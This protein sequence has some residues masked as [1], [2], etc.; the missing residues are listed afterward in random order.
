MRSRTQKSISNLSVDLIGHALGLIQREA[1]PSYQRNIEGRDPPFSRGEYIPSAI[2]ILLLISG[3]DYHLARLKY[4]TDGVR[5]KPPLPYTPDLEWEIDDFFYTKID[6][7]LIKRTEKRLKEQLIELTMMRDSVAHPK[8]YLI[9]QLMRPDYSFTK[10][11]AKLSGG[12][13]HGKKALQRKLKRSERSKCLGL[14]LVPTWISYVDIVL[15]VLVLNRLLNLLEEK[16]GKFYSLIG[17]LEAR[18]A[19]PGFFHGWGDK[20]RRSISMEEWAQAFFDSLSPRDQRNVEKRLG[21]EASR[22]VRK[23]P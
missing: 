22:Y 10:Q 18:N 5:S 13:K 1:F 15:C 21:T 2:A 20:T 19:P 11:K 6:Q 8:L 9:S 3:L 12:A 16:Y 14:P 23:R 17:G 4:F 7:L